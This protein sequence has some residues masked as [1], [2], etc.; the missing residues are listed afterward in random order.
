MNEPARDLEMIPSASTDGMEEIFDSDAL[1]A[2]H[3]AYRSG[4]GSSIRDQGASLSVIGSSVRDKDAS[5]RDQ[6]AK[7]LTVE[8][9][10][11]RLGI[12]VRAVQKRLKR[13]T[14]R[15]TKEKTPH[16]E[17]WFVDGRELDANQDAPLSVMGSPVRDTDATVRD[18]DA[19]PHE[20]RDAVI[21]DLQAKVEALTW[22]NGYLESQLETQREQIK[23]LTDSQHQRKWW[24][25]F[26]SWAMGKTE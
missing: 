23:L 20:L 25:R 9:A 13:G 4:G 15:G 22:R 10:A 21:M 16:G 8:E 5:V 1:D 3:D 26:A 24:H 6:D 12:S 18:Q 17:R 11:E 14:L 19:P 2:S 7:S